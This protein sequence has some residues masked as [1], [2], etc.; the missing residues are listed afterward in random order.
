MK[1]S[2]PAWISR[3]AMAL[4]LALFAVTLYFIDR[5]ATAREFRT[6]GLLL[7]VILLP[8]AGWHV[9]RTLLSMQ[10]PPREVVV[11]HLRGSSAQELFVEIL[12]GSARSVFGGEPEA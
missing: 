12:L 1:P 2:V 9:V 3:A 11:L 5:E 4:G 7:P 10:P 8:S 6:L